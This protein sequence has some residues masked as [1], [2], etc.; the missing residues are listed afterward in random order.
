[1]GEDAGLG[2]QGGRL[3]TGSAAARQLP[4]L[5]GGPHLTH[6]QL[7]VLVQT[8]RRKAKIIFAGR[9]GTEVINCRRARW[10]VAQRPD[11]RGEVIA[12]DVFPRQIGGM[13]VSAINI[14]ADH[15]SVG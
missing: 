6:V 11:A 5:P 1:M 10:V 9:H 2:E 3:W 15:T 12:E 7:I 13:L 4:D 8:K 14:A